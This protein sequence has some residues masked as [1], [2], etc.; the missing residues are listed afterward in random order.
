MK[1]LR[2][3]GV[4][5]LAALLIHVPALVY[6]DA[7][8]HS[9]INNFIWTTQFAEAFSRGDFYPRWFPESF[10][11]LGSPTFYFYPPLAFW[12]SGFWAAIGFDAPS[13]VVIA[14]IFFSAASGIAMYFWLAPRTRHALLWAIAYMI[15]PY[16]LYDFYVRGA[17]AEYA[18]FIWPPLILLAI[19]GLPDRRRVGLLAISYAGLIVTHL[20]AALLATVFL[21][22]PYGLYQCYLSRAKLVPGLAGALL[23]LGLASF[24]VLPALTLQEH[25]STDWLWSGFYQPSFWFPW[26]RFEVG[27][28]LGRCALAVALLICGAAARNVFGFVTC[29]IA[30]ASIG[31]IPFVWDVDLL[32][33]VQFPWRLLALAEFAA[34]TAVAMGVRFTGVLKGGMLVGIL[35]CVVF[36]S[37]AVETFRAPVDFAAIDRDRP[38]APEYLPRGLGDVGVSALQRIPDLT[39]FEHLPRGT[40]IEV[41]A[42]GPVTVGHADFP[43][44]QV[45]R[46][47]EVIQHSGPLITFDAPASGTYVIERRM[48][49]IETVG[50]ALS[51]LAC[52]LLLALRFIRPGF[53]VLRW[54]R[55]QGHGR[56]DAVRRD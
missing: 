8:T 30:A 52:A 25:I 5:A 7:N 36:A 12:V 2:I 13:A 39:A 34:I 56:A 53:A 22:A 40:R 37:A 24:Y 32:A 26:N 31:L 48:L 16:H 47:G 28:L 44:W 50:W 3:F 21:V 1:E 33:R 27:H 4:I 43:I 29:F 49:P 41:S 23:G 19:D 9:A 35:P 46:G 10:E 20:P 51:A 18:A 6:S 11:G 14:A 15:A 45:V 54:R 55:G 38:D 42:P 17:L